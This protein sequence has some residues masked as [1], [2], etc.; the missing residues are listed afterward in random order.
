MPF[1][2]SVYH[3]PADYPGPDTVFVEAKTADE[4]RQQAVKLFRERNPKKRV[5]ATWV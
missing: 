4:A 3:W 1:T 5:I 2:V